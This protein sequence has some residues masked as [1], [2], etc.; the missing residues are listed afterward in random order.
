VFVLRLQSTAYTHSAITNFTQY[1]PVLYNTSDNLLY[2]HTMNRQ[3]GLT[4]VA[5]SKNGTVTPKRLK[6]I[7]FL[8]Q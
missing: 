6:E 8:N 5:A 3:V 1:I 7:V 2:R 4:D